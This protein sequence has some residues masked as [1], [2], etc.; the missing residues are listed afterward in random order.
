MARRKFAIFKSILSPA[1]SEPLLTPVLQ[2][3]SHYLLASSGVSPGHALR[4]LKALDPQASLTLPPRAQDTFDPDNQK[5]L[6]NIQQRG[7]QVMIAESLARS[8]RDFDAFLEEKLDLNWEEQR[9]KIFRHFGL[10]QKDDSASDSLGA[11]ARGSFGRSMRPSRQGPIS[12]EVPSTAS[13]SVFGRSG[14]VKS[15]I[16]APATGPTSPRFF[17]DP[18]ER[19]EGPGRRSDLRFLREKMGQYAEKVQRLNSV[20]L[21]GHAF[22]ILHE[23]SEIEDIGGDVS[24]NARIYFSSTNYLR[25]LGSS[26]MR[27]KL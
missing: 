5:F 14:L 18:S 23:F 15:V 24:Y 20:R 4:D 21:Q 17:E 8:Q 16:G 3:R 7:R 1:S 6:K 26:S 2:F 19:N 13:R 9:Q 25:F 27:T 11:I 22:P 12:F 10:A